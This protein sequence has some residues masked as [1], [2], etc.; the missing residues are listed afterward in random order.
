MGG[1]Y[2]ENGGEEGG[3]VGATVEDYSN[4]VNVTRGSIRGDE[5][6]FMVNEGDEDWGAVVGWGWNKS[7]Y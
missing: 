7:L 3:D 4:S 6:G 2:E 5:D 1:G